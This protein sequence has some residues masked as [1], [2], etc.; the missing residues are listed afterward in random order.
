MKG[1]PNK[2]IDNSDVQDFHFA[3]AGVRPPVTIKASTYQKAL[4]IWHKIGE[5]EEPKEIL[6]GE[7]EKGSPTT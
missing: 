1:A 7:Y 2:M 5:V 4:E 3:G 6:T